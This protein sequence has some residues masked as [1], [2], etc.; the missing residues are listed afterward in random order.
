MAV[1][2]DK[3]DNT[4]RA[5]FAFSFCGDFL[6]FR[7]VLSPHQT[8]HKLAFAIRTRTKGGRKQ[9]RTKS[10][11]ENISNFPPIASIERA[12]DDATGRFTLQFL[13]DNVVGSLLAS[14]LGDDA[15]PLLR[16]GCC[17]GRC[18]TWRA[19][20]FKQTEQSALCRLA[21][22]YLDAGCLTPSRKHG[23]NVCHR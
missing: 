16:S 8:P 15:H 5:S 19:A 9:E 13:G 17:R 3:D 7:V 6:N 18:E 1:R 2:Y 12:K 20:R 14:R 11:I 21:T 10:T 23:A 4:K 22:R